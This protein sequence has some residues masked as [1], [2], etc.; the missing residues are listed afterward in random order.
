M[1][2]SLPAMRRAG[3]A[4]LLGAALPVAALAATSPPASAASQPQGPTIGADIATKCKAM[5]GDERKAC[6][7]DTRTAAR[8]RRAHHPARSAHSSAHAASGAS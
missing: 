7:S 1:I 6:I 2:V 4:L 3:A 8:T 5:S